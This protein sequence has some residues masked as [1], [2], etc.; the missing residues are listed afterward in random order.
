MINQPRGAC[1]ELHHTELGPLL[2]KRNVSR[3]GRGTDAESATVSSAR[4][5]VFCPSVRPCSGNGDFVE[6]ALVLSWTGVRCLGWGPTSG[7]KSWRTDR[8]AASVSSWA[9]FGGEPSKRRR[10]S[11]K[12]VHHALFSCL[13]TL[14]PL[15]M[16]AVPYMHTTYRTSNN[17]ADNRECQPS[18]H[19]ATPSH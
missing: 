17:C 13:M 5:S 12:N 3:H 6:A 14:K 15:L 10:R 19:R 2:R 7:R 11:V 9:S 18:P 1:P 4:C 8:A 16:H